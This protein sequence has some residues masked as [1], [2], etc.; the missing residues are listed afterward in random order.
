MFQSWNPWKTKIYLYLISCANET[1]GDWRGIKIKR[2][3]TIRS[4]RTIQ[5]DISYIIQYSQ[6]ANRNKTPSTTTVKRILNDLKMKHL[7]EVEVLQF[8][9]LININ[10]YNRLISMPFGKVL[11]LSQSEAVQPDPDKK[12]GGLKAPDWM[13]EHWG[14]KPK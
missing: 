2:G 5:S 10:N 6:D 9:M 4:I 1:D 14:V 11:Q 3:Q 7:I 8:G 12:Y 13:L